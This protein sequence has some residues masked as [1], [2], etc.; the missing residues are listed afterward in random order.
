MQSTT[1]MDWIKAQWKEIDL[2]HNRLLSL[3][4]A[5][6]LNSDTL[7]KTIT[8]VKLNQQPLIIRQA[9]EKD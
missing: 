7:I 3:V 4:P 8:E 9:K 2:M 1:Y 5:Y 6:N